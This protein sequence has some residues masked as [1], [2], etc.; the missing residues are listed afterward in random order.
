MDGEFCDLCLTKMEQGVEM[1]VISKDRNVM[2]TK[3][4]GLFQ[5]RNVTGDILAD[6]EDLIANI[7]RGDNED[8]YYFW[9]VVLFIVFL[10]VL[11]AAIN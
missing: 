8:N 10:M 6:D 2:E 7:H 4:H 3:S 1:S 9:M 11:I 5:T